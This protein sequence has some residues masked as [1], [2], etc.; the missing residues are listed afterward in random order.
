MF[1]NIYCKECGRRLIGHHE[2]HDL[3][4][5][6]IKAGDLACPKH[7]LINNDILVEVYRG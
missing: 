4:R 5:F 1:V 2:S 7:G 3:V 6:S